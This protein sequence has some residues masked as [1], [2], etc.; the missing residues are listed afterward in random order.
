MSEPQDPKAVTSA[1]WDALYARHW[2][3]VRSF[4]GPES[5]YLD[6]SIGPAAAARGPE[7]IEKRL[8]LGL[9]KLSGYGPR[10][11]HRRGRGRH[12][13]HRAHRDVGVADGRDGDPAVRLG[14]ARRR[15]HD[16]AVEGPPGRRHA[17]GSAPPDRMEQLMA[18][19]MS[20]MTDV[21]GLI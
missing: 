4:S 17:R 12:R 2:E 6:V 15:R 18:G 3:R 11:R 8:L 14:A 1:F 10:P 21:T 20:W 16:H 5:T 19:D 13:R 9:E 7:N